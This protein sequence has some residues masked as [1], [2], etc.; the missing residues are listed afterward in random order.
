MAPRRILVVGNY[1]ADQQ[2]SM[3]RFA[4][5]LVRFYQ[6]HGQVQLLRPPVLVARLPGLPPLA[7]KYLAYV[8]K[9]LLFPLWLALRA[10]FCQLVHIADHSNAYYAFC[11]SRHRCIVT[12]HDLL[13]VRGAMGD[14]AVAC[15]ASPIGIWLQKLILAGLRQPSAVAFDSQAS[16]NDFHRLGGGPSRQRHAVIPIPLNAP[17]TQN[18]A[19]LELSTAEQA[20]RPKP[21]YLLMVG[22][23]LPR[24]NRALALRLLR[25]LGSASPYSVVF[26]GAPL[27]PEEQAFIAAHHLGRQVVSI[28]RP[29]HA[30]LNH[31]YGRAHALLFPSLAEGFGWPLIEAQASGCPVIASTTTSIPE[32]AGSAALYADPSD[33]DTFASHV[34][35]LEAPALRRRLIQ[36]GFENLRRFD[37]DVISRQYV[38][39]ALQPA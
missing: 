34:L 6:P 30:L 29:S 13:A 14:P 24:K 16:L 21:P 11:C 38:R 37:P 4:D 27:A 33:V 8:D 28:V 5:L 17:F 19:S 39:F 10:R 9:L 22:S 32:V 3:T 23:A 2:Q 36:L 15:E 20:L 35:A 1:P 12:C 31:L 25:H 7:R 18:I 26:A